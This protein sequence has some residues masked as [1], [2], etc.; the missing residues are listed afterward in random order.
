HRLSIA[1]AVELSSEEEAAPDAVGSSLGLAGLQ[2]SLR[3]FFQPS[4]PDAQ[5]PV[6][7][8]PGPS[9][10]VGRPLSQQMK[11]LIARVAEEQAVEQK[12]GQKR[13]W[14]GSPKGKTSGRQEIPVAVRASLVQEMELSVASNQFSDETEFF[15]HFA[16]KFSL[17]KRKVKDLWNRRTL[18]KKTAQRHKLSKKPYKFSGSRGSRKG[19]LGRRYKGLRMP[20]AGRKHSFPHLL[21]E[22][23]SWFHEMRSYGN[24]VLRVDLYNYYIH[25][26]E[27]ERTR[28]Q[29][30]LSDP[31]M[32]LPQRA[33]LQLKISEIEKQLASQ[34]KSEKAKMPSHMA[35]FRQ[36]SLACCCSDETT[37]GQHVSKPKQFISERQNLAVLFADQ[38]P[39]WIK[40]GSE[41]ELFADFERA[42]TSQAALRQDLKAL[43][44]QQL[45]G[46]QQVE[47]AL[48]VEH[49]DSTGDAGQRQL[50]SRKD[51]FAFFYVREAAL[52]GLNSA[53]EPTGAV[54]K[55]L[56]ITAGPHCRL[57]NISEG[58]TWFSDESFE[59]R[60][61]MVTHKKGVSVG[62][63]MEPW[64]A[65]RAKKP[66]LFEHI[67]VMSQPSSN[68]DS[69]ILSW[70]A[71]ELSEEFPALL[72]QRDCL[73][74]SFS[75]SVSQAHFLGNTI[76]TLIAP[77]MTDFSRRFRALCRSTM[78]EK[79]SLG[80][81]ALR[82]A[83]KSDIWTAFIDDIA[84]TIVSAQQ[85]T[86]EDASEWVLAGLRRN[87]LLAYRPVNGTLQP[88]EDSTPSFKELPQSSARL[89]SEWMA[90]RFSWLK[91][92][93]PSEP[94]WSLIPGTAAAQELLDWDVSHGDKNPEED[95]L[96]DMG[97][98][99][100]T[101]RWECLESGL[102]KLPPALLQKA[103]KRE[104][105][106]A[107]EEKARLLSKK[108]HWQLV[109]QAKKSLSDKFK[110]AMRKKLMDISRQQA[111]QL[112]A[113][114]TKL[115]AL[116]AAKV[117]APQQGPLC[118]QQVRICVEMLPSHHVG[119]EGSCKSHV[120]QKVFLPGFGSAMGTLTLPEDH[121]VLVSPTWKTP[122]VWQPLRLSR[123]FKKEVLLSCGLWCEDDSFVPEPVEVTH[124]KKT[125]M[126][127]DQHLNSGWFL[128][129]EHFGQKGLL[130]VFFV[131]A[132]LLAFLLLE[133]EKGE[134]LV[135]HLQ[136]QWDEHSV[137]Y[138]P[139][140][141]KDPYHWS[142]LILSKDSENKA[143]LAD[144]LKKD[145]APREA[146]TLIKNLLMSNEVPLTMLFTG[147]Q[148]SDDC[149]FWILAFM[150]E[151]LSERRGEGP[152]ARGSQHAVVAELKGKL[153]IFTAQ[154][155]AEHGKL[156]QERENFLMD[157][158][159]QLKAASDRAKKLAKAASDAKGKLSDLQKAALK[160]V[161]EGSTPD[162]SDLGQE[163][164]LDI[165]RVKTLGDPKICSRCHWQSGCPSCDVWK[166]QRYHLRVL[167][168]SLGQEPPEWAR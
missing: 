141:T 10:Y 73:G 64:R 160:V 55:S 79:R 53:G 102:L 88:A 59:W 165:E 123:V 13:S 69:I 50:R 99:P 95:Y 84:E 89:R 129:K 56:I 128:L 62:R 91:D 142:L 164:L 77:K 166:C 2:A 159:S 117:S 81:K 144:S 87:G 7:F 109:S 24:Q 78:A 107:D 42:P 66:H 49:A 41:K 19:A 126:L 145:A 116:S 22:L 30:Q 168:R 85:A 134:H 131:D 151:H 8:S 119:Q 25:L 47:S 94:D 120:S 18:V 21:D 113:G 86:A 80:S 132:C 136:K 108:V 111:A 3:R 112:V 161:K 44:E 43:H 125:L 105:S 133:H 35:V 32:L 37:L 48:V 153:S 34:K 51:M 98:L 38:V 137:L 106:L 152:K 4:H 71:Q 122:F 76:Q 36:G 28:L 103:W 138:V 163:A 17:Q 45:S 90:P 40:A 146:A 39:L 70:V 115:K 162:L 57:S 150:V 16:R 96:C 68:A 61:K 130:D 23:R 58:G 46:K 97:A 147:A 1:M 101:L 135:S 27:T 65:L 63:L 14:G 67:C 26:F 31:K 124:A 118:G 29:A 110:E 121:V 9:K 6:Q 75:E 12:E 100:P 92:G 60:G 82:D 83:G 15:S 157:Q 54:Y 155:R 148:T 149:G 167:C 158:A 104:A 93:I 140:Y 33:P 143:V 114:K 11:N 5:K 154:L 74:A 156:F 52:A 127:L 139:I 20:G 72:V